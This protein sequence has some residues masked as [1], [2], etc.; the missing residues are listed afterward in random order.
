ME[1]K[2]ACGR[3]REGQECSEQHLGSLQTPHL[4]RHQ[5]VPQVDTGCGVHNVE[6]SWAGSGP[7]HPHDA[8]WRQ[9]P[10]SDGQRSVGAV[11]SAQH[12]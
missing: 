7:V 12:G 10:V 8:G 5:E 11:Q 6:Q 4:V 9:V 2:G 3:E 1:G